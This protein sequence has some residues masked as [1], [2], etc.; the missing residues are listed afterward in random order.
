MISPSDSRNSS[1][2]RWIGIAGCCAL[3]VVAILQW[4]SISLLRQENELLR[5]QSQAAPPQA[6]SQS[7]ASAAVEA[8]DSE[9][10]QQE[11]LELLRLR[12]EVRQLREQAAPLTPDTQPVASPP[13]PST[14]PAVQSPGEE[15]RRLGGAALQG[16]SSALDKLAHL[17]IAVRTMKPEEAAA[18]FAGI[19]SAFELLGTEAGR[20]NTAGLQALWQASRIR[21][22]QG[23]AVKALGQAAGLGNEE[24]LKPLLDPESYL[25]LR[26]S[27]T[28]ALK[29]AADAGNERAI[30][31]LA[32]TAADPK[33]QALWLLAAQG[34]ETAAAAGNPTAIDGLAA[35]AAAQNQIIRRQ[36]VL[37]LEA[38]ARKNQPRAEE[39]LRKLGWR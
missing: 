6:S 12:N 31:A 39:A 33:Q 13:P 24:A 29:P 8:I 28:A 16:D 5:A 22:L 23:F 1:T 34:L 35:L 37:A 18:A 30:Q 26:S 25:L 2:R 7:A 15:I 38:A 36:A 19:Q 20:G 4:R 3:L 10:W 14:A 27:T 32:A 11:R 9:Q 21:D 17:A